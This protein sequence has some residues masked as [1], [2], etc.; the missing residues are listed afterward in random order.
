MHTGGYEMNFCGFLNEFSDKNE[1]EIIIKGTVSAEIISCS[2]NSITINV[3]QQDS[4]LD[5]I[6]GFAALDYDNKFLWYN[7]AEVTEGNNTIAFDGFDYF[8][9]ERAPIRYKLY[10]VFEEEGVLHFCRFYNQE[11]KEKYKA[12]YDRNLLYY[13]VIAEGRFEDE[14]YCTCLSVT[15]GGYFALLVFNKRIFTTLD[16]LILLMMWK[17]LMVNGLLMLRLT[18][19]RKHRNGHL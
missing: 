12:T 17:L 9:A 7:E 18:R 10:A 16:L 13:D 8:V 15:R 19:L 1:K 6:I 14:D 2:S 4:N 11:I 3:P 5:S